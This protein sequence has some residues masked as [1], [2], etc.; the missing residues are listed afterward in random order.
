M[1]GMHPSQRAA[2]RRCTM[3]YRA[4]CTLCGADVFRFD[5]L[6]DEHIQAMLEHMW[7]AHPDVLRRPTTLPLDELLREVR[8]RME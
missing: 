8:I 1:R 6:D 2:R 7:I 3:S 4:E 5:R